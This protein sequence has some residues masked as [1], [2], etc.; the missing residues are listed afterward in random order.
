VNLLAAARHPL[1]ALR[2][3]GH[4]PLHALLAVALLAGVVG[5]PGGAQAAEPATGESGELAE[6]GEL[7][8]AEDNATAASREA[9]ADTRSEAGS[10]VTRR[11]PDGPRQDDG[12]LA[13]ISGICVYLPPGYDSGT[14]RYP[15]I[16]LLHGGFGAQNDW[17]SQGDMQQIMDAHYADD[18]AN[19]AIVVMPDG[20]YD[21]SWWDVPG[22][23]PQ[24][25][26][27]VIDHVIPY[28]DSR[29]RTIADRAGRAITGL[30]QGGAGTARLASLHPDL[31]VAAAPMSAA[32][33]VN[34]FGMSPVG[35]GGP[36]P[37]DAQH[38]A[39]DPFEIV[40]NLDPVA[41]S[42]I[43]GRTCGDASAPDACATYGPAYAF[44]HACCTNEAYAAKLQLIRETPFDFHPVVG[45][46]DWVYWK[47]WLR[48]TS[49][50][51][52]L[53]HM[54]DPQPVGSATVASPAPESF[55][56]RS[57]RPAFD[58]FG[59]DLNVT[60]RPAREFLSLT[61]VTAAGLTLRGSGTVHVTTPADYAAGAV[62]TVAGG[63][64]DA[65]AEVVADDAG[66]LTFTVDLGPGHTADQYSP[67]AY[68]AEIAAG[69]SYWTTRTVEIAPAG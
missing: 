26:T 43:Y 8:P 50:E 3:A 52:V 65:A 59:Y 44:E 64:G 21:A 55:R 41:L 37:I 2:V 42:L 14:L 61:D 28:V 16:Y 24:N 58:I 20:T 53:G 67:Q 10:L 31:F 30:S 15:V 46:H 27:Y 25:E 22:G 9:C 1:H 66:R 63:G 51:F 48:G 56:Y 38:V 60:D 17:V 47:A 68:A 5:L 54:A 33:P 4:H 62:Y 11:L 29:F 34:T 12:S 45:G 6:P 7:D 35:G 19:A 57:I 39:N 49:G 18:P 69:G 40:D 13:F 36:N 23:Y 32:F